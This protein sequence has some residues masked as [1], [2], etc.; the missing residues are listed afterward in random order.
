MAGWPQVGR[1]AGFHL[2]EVDVGRGGGAAAESTAGFERSKAES[3][4]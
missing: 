4:S 3:A 1:E 2:G